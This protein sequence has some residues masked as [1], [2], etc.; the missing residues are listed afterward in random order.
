MK[1]F[2][3]TALS[4]ALL[5]APRLLPAQER[6]AAALGELV[7][8]LGTTARVLMIGAH[9]DDE[10]TH[11]I[12]WLARGRHVHTAYLSLTRGDGGQ[13]LIGNELGEA[14]GAI[15]TEELLAARRVDGGEQYFTRAYDFGFSKS[16]EETYEHWPRA[17]VLADVITT[18]RAFRPHVIVA[19][20]SGTP[21]DGHGHHQVSGML[22]REAY[23]IAGDTVRFPTAQFGPAWT[24]LKF[25]RAARFNPESGT[26]RMNVGEYSPLLGRSYAEIAAESRSQHRS[27]G[28]GSLQRKGVLFDHVRRE[29]SRVNDEQD[30]ATERSMFDG[31]DTTLARLRRPATDARLGALLDSIPA[32]I[33]AVRAVYQAEDPSPAVA[34]LAR[35][36]ALTLRASTAAGTRGAGGDA[37]LSRSMADLW[38]RAQDALLLAAGVAVEATA[39]RELVA[40][41]TN[42]DQS[43]SL[44]IV[45]SVYNRGRVPVTVNEL[46]AQFA[47]GLRRVGV[48]LA[49]DSMY[50]DSL[51]VLPLTL[52][53]QWWRAASFRSGDMFGNPVDGRSESVRAAAPDAGAVRAGVTL[54]IGDAVVT[55]MVPVVYRVADPVRGEVQRPVAVVPGVNVRLDRAMEY[56]R[57]GVALDRPLRV[58]LQSAYATPRTVRVELVLPKGITADSTGQTVTLPPGVGGAVT[59]MLRGRP[60]VGSYMVQARVTAAAD[61]FRWGYAT[62][63]YEHIAPQRLYYPAVTTIRA[64]EVT[65]PP[66]ADIAYVQGVGDNVAP[67]LRQ[68]GLPVTMLDPLSIANVDLARFTAVVVGPR[69]YEA[70]PALLANNA[71]LLEYVRRGGTMVVQYGQYEM[72]QPGVMPYPVTL[73]RPAARVTLEAAPVRL[74]TPSARL[75]T[76]PNRITAR[77]FED[78]VQER[79]TYMPAT[80]DA[81]YRP[82]LEMSDPD[83]PP[84]RGGLLVAPYGRG[85]YVYA[86]LALFRQLPAGNPGAARL[87]VNLLGA[88]AAAP[89]VVQ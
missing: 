62:V 3:V 79:A 83:E 76:V 50:R 34:P 55:A 40:Q 7:N 64:I 6:G 21:R 72:T 12:T 24:P 48:P 4:A 60:A 77:D 42:G 23:E 11:L 18:V 52:T 47:G 73:G 2:L 53:E 46:R 27:Q 26:Q 75:L 14:L 89:K 88:K 56:A 65:L 82:L 63:A 19:V 43:D 35:L 32:A 9:P 74:L 33:A 41:A 25:Y 31:I 45:V 84:Q 44:R 16:A 29:A 13:N 54:R 85:T 59:F 87:F 71:R 57:A 8:G 70:Q 49:P 20:F 37:D 78:W 17:E 38:R 22:A 36:T 61:T 1:R 28:F 81:R 39:G 15:R 68:L 67:M 58:M 51:L 10:D 66:R 5:A 86:T 30:A 69:A 80:F